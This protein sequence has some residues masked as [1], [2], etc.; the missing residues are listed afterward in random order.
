M[1]FIYMYITKKIGKSLLRG[2]FSVLT[3]IKVAITVF[4]NVPHFWYLSYISSQLSHTHS[5]CS[6]M[7]EPFLPSVTVLCIGNGPLL[8]FL[9][10][11]I[12]VFQFSSPKFIL[13]LRPLCR[14]LETHTTLWITQ[15]PLPHLSI[16]TYIHG[17]PRAQPWIHVIICCLSYSPG[18]Q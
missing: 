3:F 11:Y 14:T 5:L 2:D 9:L 10:F 13:M 17:R 12:N 4:W 7:F 16:C 1:K 18:K 8:P 6:S 15:L